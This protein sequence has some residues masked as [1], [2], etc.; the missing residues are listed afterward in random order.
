M[1]RPREIS[2]ELRENLVSLLSVLCRDAQFLFVAGRHSI[3]FL[4][5]SCLLDGLDGHIARRLDGEAH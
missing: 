2:R 5:L 1:L 3:V 4:F